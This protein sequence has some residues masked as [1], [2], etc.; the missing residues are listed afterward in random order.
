MS[1]VSWEGGNRVCSIMDLA[2]VLD[3]CELMTHV[4]NPTDLPPFILCVFTNFTIF[5]SQ[6]SDAKAF[7][8]AMQLCFIRIYKH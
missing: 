8:V 2:V 4:V 1:E 7:V 3:H 5:V 6:H